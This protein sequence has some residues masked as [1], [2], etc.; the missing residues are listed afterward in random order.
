MSTENPP[1]P[2]PTQKRPIGR[3][4]KNL[5]IW[6]FFA[7]VVAAI[8]LAFASMVAWRNLPSI[9]TLKDYKPRMAMQIF[10]DDGQLIGEF[11]EERR[12]PVL[13]SEVPDHLKKALIAIEDARFYEHDGI[14]YLG[15]GR[16]IVNNLTGGSKQGAS[17]ITQQ[18]AKNFFLTNERTFTRKFYEALMAKKIEQ[19]LTKDEILERYMN[20]IYLGERAY[21]FAA[22]A[23]IYFGKEIKDLTLAESAM[24][25][26]LPQAPSSNNPARNRKRADERQRYVLERMLELN[27]ITQAQYKQARA[28]VVQIADTKAAIRSDKYTVHADYIAEMARMLMFDRYKEAAYTEGLKVYT[29]IRS[30]EQNAAYAAVRKAVFAYDRKYGYR[31]AEAQYNL[32]SKPEERLKMLDSI[33][34]EHPDLDTLKT[35]VVISTGG[36]TFKGV[37]SDGEEITVSG[38]NLGPAKNLLGSGDKK[39]IRIGSVV[40]VIE[41]SDGSNYRITQVPSV[42][43]SFV[44]MDPTDGAIHALIGGFDFG[45]SKFNHITQGYRQPGSTIKPFI[46]SA[47]MEKNGMNPNSIV[48]DKPIKVGSWQPKNADGRYLGPIPLSTALAFS[49]NMVSIRLLQSIGNDYFR[50]YAER[51]GFEGKRIDKFLTVALGAIEATPYEIVGAYGVFANGGYKVDPYFIKKVVDRSGRVILEAKP[52]LANDEKN[53]VITKEN[54]TM[55]DALLKGVVRGGTAR[56]ASA[57]GRSDIAGKTGTTNDAVDAWF[58]GYQPKLVGVAWMGFDTGNKSLGEGEF[59]G[60]LALPIWMDYMRMALQGKKVEVRDTQWQNAATNARGG[61]ATRR[62]PTDPSLTIDGQPAP[63]AAPE[64]LNADPNTV[65]LPN[66][67]ARKA[68]EIVNEADVKAAPERNLEEIIA[69]VKPAAPTQPKPVKPIAAPN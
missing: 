42:Q 6:G 21:G 11:G 37:T 17:T 28:E 15:L 69:P 43:A 63:P 27:F 51:F 41:S 24:L 13:V 39:G 50:S 19:N 60:C 22:A 48:D 38:A 8:V 33:F 3:I 31:G 65:P 56:A 23:D 55:T 59:G 62:N 30:Q 35:V 45:L 58:A 10:S 57:L 52:R 14:D 2:Q 53:R 40:R 5:F 44:S 66:S 54:A 34:E 12:K 25:A 32:P 26:T 1:N 7:A 49:R 68:S 4:F 20:H 9:D 67:D 36:G 46:Y 61:N 18:L 47:A 64:E 29:T 16:A